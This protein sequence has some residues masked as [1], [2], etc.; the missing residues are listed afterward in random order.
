MGVPESIIFNN[1]FT[2]AYTSKKAEA[3]A[4][5]FITYLF[6]CLVSVNGIQ[7]IKSYFQTSN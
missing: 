2:L 7:I 4:P 3:N 5:A 1:S 6:F